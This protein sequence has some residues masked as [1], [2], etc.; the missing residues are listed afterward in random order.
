[1]NEFKFDKYWFRTFWI[2]KVY[3]IINSDRLY[4]L[5]KFPSYIYIYIYSM[6]ERI[7]KN[8]FMNLYIYIMLTCDKG[9]AVH[10]LSERDFKLNQKQMTYGRRKKLWQI[11]EE[12]V[13]PSSET[14]WR[15][16]GE[17]EEEERKKITLPVSV[18]LDCWPP[19][20]KNFF[21][22]QAISLFNEPPTRILTSVNCPATIFIFFYHY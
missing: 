15:K 9:Y 17:M 7:S 5:V 19:S 18:E 8:L 14:K 11:W 6:N 22:H 16:K 1:M 2:I 21:L 10:Y 13:S 20:T 3:L 12:A 4:I